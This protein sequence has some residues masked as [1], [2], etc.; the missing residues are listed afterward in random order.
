MNNALK[1]LSCFHMEYFLE[2]RKVVWRILLG[3]LIPVNP[4]KKSKRGLRGEYE[5]CSDVRLI[6]WLSFNLRFVK[7]ALLAILIVTKL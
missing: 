1:M 6:V 2:E 5:K 4:T 7:L 3:T